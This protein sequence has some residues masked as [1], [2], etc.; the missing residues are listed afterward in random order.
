VALLKR[1][2]GNHLASSI[3]IF[4][5]RTDE[6]DMSNESKHYRNMGMAKPGLRSLAMAVLVVRD[7]HGFEFLDGC[8]GMDPA[9]AEG[10]SGCHL[11]HAKDKAPKLHMVNQGPHVMNQLFF[12]L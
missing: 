11:P 1:G 5:E 4:K 2:V 9:S 12:S 10:G 6:V 7:V 3:L 8:V